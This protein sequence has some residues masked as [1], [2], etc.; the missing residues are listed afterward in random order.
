MFLLFAVV[1][2]TAC[3]KANIFDSIAGE[4]WEREIEGCGET[5]CFSDD[6]TFIYYEHCGNP[7]EDYDCFDT[8]SFNEKTG[9]ITLYAIEG[10]EKRE[11]EI[12]SCE[13][14]TL[15]LRFGTE[16]REFQKQEEVANDTIEPILLSS[17][18]MYTEYDVTGDGK[19][20]EFQIICE[21]LT[22]AYED[23]QYGTK[24]SITLNGEK[25][26]TFEPELMMNLEVHLYR[27]GDQRNYLFIKQNLDTNDDIIGAELY[28]FTEKTIVEEI[29]FYELLSEN[30]NMF[31]CGISISFMTQRYLTMS[32]YNQFNAT[33]YMSWEMNYEYKKSEDAWIESDESY[34]LMYDDFLEE[35]GKGMT[36]NQD[37]IVYEDWTCEEEAFTVKKDEVVH[38][39][40]IR[41]YNGKTYFHVESEDGN[42]GWMPDPDM[43]GEEIDGE[44]IMG[45]FKEALF[46]G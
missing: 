8:Y 19:K 14:D 23:V 29:D 38:L 21:E 36:A 33:A 5:L 18:V 27:A 43:P 34:L 16:K 9:V 4:S 31:H 3:A 7:V 30:I 40:A 39:G 1:F 22:E 17:D 26:L 28:R 12:V 41:F 32:C 24:W 46:A 25:A 11:I 35:K 42:Q 13:N 6:G 2:L 20:D 15:V 10:N 45:Y 44:Y 37:F